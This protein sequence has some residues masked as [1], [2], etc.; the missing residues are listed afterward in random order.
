[1]KRRLF[2][3]STT[4][5]TITITTSSSLSGLSC[6]TWIIDAALEC[7]S[8]RWGL[9]CVGLREARQPGKGRKGLDILKFLSCIAVVVEHLR[10]QVFLLNSEELSKWNSSISFW[11]FLLPQGRRSLSCF[12]LISYSWQLEW[13][14]V[15]FDLTFFL[16]SRSRKLDSHEIE[17]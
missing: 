5:T 2:L 14:E 17:F 10:I 6:S 16:M 13:C 1:M 12:A 15:M 8:D 9:C 4:I 11:Y 3:P 7:H